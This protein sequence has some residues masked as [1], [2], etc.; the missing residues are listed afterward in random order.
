M[1]LWCN[2]SLAPGKMRATDRGF[3]LLEALVASALLA[4]GLS[5]AI[6]LSLA[7][8]AATQTNRNLDMAS[9]LAQ[10]L[11]EC[12]GLQTSQCQNMFVQ[13][14]SLQPFSANPHLTFVR[15]WQVHSI[16]LQGM[17][18]EHLQE[19]QISVSWQEGSK[20]PEIQWRQ[21]RAN[22]PLWVGL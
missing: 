10:D 22:T 6:R 8:L 14:T 17:P 19:L 20:K 7:S 1:H 21:R 11:A 9:A 15:T 13:S 12:W 5:G 3:T 2:A 16:P 4:F 18:A